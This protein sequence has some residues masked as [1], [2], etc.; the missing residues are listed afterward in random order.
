MEKDHRK[1]IVRR[2]KEKEKFLNVVSK[3]REEELSELKLTRSISLMDKLDNVNR[4]KRIDEF[5]KMQ[6]LQKINTD[7]VRS[8]RIKAEREYLINQRKV[9]KC[10]SIYFIN[11]TNNFMLIM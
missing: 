7:D 4:I 8:E 5:V 6:T 3:Q 11:W 9:T 2:R 10:P 1:D